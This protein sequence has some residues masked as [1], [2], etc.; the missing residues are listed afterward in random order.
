MLDHSPSDN[1]RLTNNS[2]N[3]SSTY[4]DQIKS[5]LVTAVE[6]DSKPSVSIATTWKWRGEYF[7]LDC[8]TLPI[9]YN[10]EC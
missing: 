2:Q 9:P 4:F 6:G 7:S 1:S 8:P 3:I 10:A 5:K